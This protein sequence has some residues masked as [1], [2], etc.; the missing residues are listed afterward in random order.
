MLVKQPIYSLTDHILKRL[1][2]SSIEQSFENWIYGNDPQ[3]DNFD[4]LH[5]YGDQRLIDRQ[6]IYCAN[7]DIIERLKNILLV[8]IYMNLM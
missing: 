5:F 2:F 4:D 8:Y 6:Q 7:D 1:K 3:N